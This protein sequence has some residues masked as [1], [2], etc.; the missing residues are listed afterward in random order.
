MASFR[1][2]DLFTDKLLDD[3]REPFMKFMVPSIGEFAVMAPR[4]QF[5]TQLAYVRTVSCVLRRIEHVRMM[6]EQ[7]QTCIVKSMC[8]SLISRTTLFVYSF[9]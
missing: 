5:W 6:R 7:T 3:D 4:M 2:N 8:S 9:S 1:L